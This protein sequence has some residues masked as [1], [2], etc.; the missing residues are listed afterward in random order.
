[1][2][3]D[4][5]TGAYDLSQW[6]WLF[7]CLAALLTGMSKSGLGGVFAA[8]VPLMVLVFPPKEG[9][10]VLMPMLIVAD[11]AAIIYYNRSANWSYILKLL[12]WTFA[13]IILG[14]IVGNM[15][16]DEVFRYAIG[17][18]IFL[19]AVILIWLEVQQRQDIPDNPWFS[20]IAGLL[21]GFSTMVG[22]FA[23]PIIT[24]YLLSMRL[25]KNTFIG[26]AAWFFFIIN[27]S[28]LIPHLFYWQ[29]ISIDSA[30]L[31]VVLI[32]IIL[33]GALL[34]IQIVKQFSERFFRLFTI[35]VTILSI[36]IVFLK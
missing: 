8:V 27:L 7:L 23:G 2:T 28:K 5:L 24:V 26:T 15:V 16:S 32:P 10:G 22:N 33:L 14:S 13:G 31:D 20:A 1:M 11:T 6:D 18:I 21:G 29:T 9:L 17:I 12:P 30:K 35:V 4:F 36:V 3:L 25:P 19:G 34:G